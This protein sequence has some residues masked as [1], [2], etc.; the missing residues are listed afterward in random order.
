VG[1]PL[2]PLAPHYPTWIIQEPCA[3]EDADGLISVLD[4]ILI[5]PAG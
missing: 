3:D 5:I 1:H 2:D 4:F